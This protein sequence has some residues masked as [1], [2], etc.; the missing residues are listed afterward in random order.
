[1]EAAS[2]RTEFSREEVHRRQPWLFLNSRE[3]AF[4]LSDKLIEPDEFKDKARAALAER[5][6]RMTAKTLQAH[7]R[8]ED[9][10]L[11]QAAARA[12]AMKE[13]TALVPELIDLLQDADSQVRRAGRDNHD[14]AK[15]R[16]GGLA[17]GHGQ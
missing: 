4:T 7:L 14:K 6:A 15:P 1:M 10:E 9:K 13:N 16:S 8:G 17:G 3:Y 2:L 5:L 12:C 11:R